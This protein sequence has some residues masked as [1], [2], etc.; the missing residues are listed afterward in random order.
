MS[1]E[2][3]SRLDECMG[4]CT[5]G[6]RC[7]SIHLSQS[8]KKLL[9]CRQQNQPVYLS[10]GF[11]PIFLVKRGLGTFLLSLEEAELL[12]APQLGPGTPSLPQTPAGEV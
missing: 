6:R 12:H 10:L 9:K 2:F 11:M 1:S 4:P 8:N 3:V 7:L 5:A